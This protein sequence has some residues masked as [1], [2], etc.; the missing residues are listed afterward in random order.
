MVALNRQS[1]EMLR[2]L[3]ERRDRVVTRQELVDRFWSSTPA[4]AEDRLNTCIRRMRAVLDVDAG[5]SCIET[6]PRVGYRY[7]GSFAVVSPKQP[8][9]RASL[10]ILWKKVKSVPAVAAALGALFAPVLLTNSVSART[11]DS[12]YQNDGYT[13]EKYGD[14]SSNCDFE[15]EDGPGHCVISGD[16]R[17]RILFNGALIEEAVVEQQKRLTCSLNAGEA[18]CS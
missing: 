5:D 14:I 9:M 3:A 6:H 11:P 1:A 15:Y 13:I 7:A 8:E 10:E 12:Q 16:G 18:D 17:V 4:G 2:Y